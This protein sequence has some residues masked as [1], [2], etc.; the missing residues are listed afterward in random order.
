MTDAFWVSGMAPA[1]RRRRA[2]TR[3]D[4]LR[5]AVDPGH[6]SFDVHYRRTD[7]S[8]EVFIVVSIERVVFVVFVFRSS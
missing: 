2:F 7:D 4:A 5:V 3:Q 1:R 8:I 6:R